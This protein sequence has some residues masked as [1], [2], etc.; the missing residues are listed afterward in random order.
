MALTFH[1]DAAV[2][3]A[4]LAGPPQRFHAVVDRHFDAVAAFLARRVGPD[5][6]QDLAQEVFVTAFRKRAKFDPTYGSARPWLFGIAN[7]AIASHRREERRQ[8]ELLQ[9]AVALPEPPATPADGLDP[10]LYTGLTALNRRDRDALLLHAWGELS[11]EEIAHALNVP[12][13]TV[14]S[15][16]HRARRQLTAHLGGDR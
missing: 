15:R 14:R 3:A 7:K 10:H 11:Y 8:L 12:L 1:T 2:D 6:A 4:D 5:T 13:G 16:I 9:R